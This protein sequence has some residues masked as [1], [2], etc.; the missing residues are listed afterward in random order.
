MDYIREEFM[1]QQ[2]ALLVLMNGH[3]QSVEEERDLPE[4]QES[5]AE[6][7]LDAEIAAQMRMVTA[8]KKLKANRVQLAEQETHG[9]VRQEVFAKEQMSIRNRIIRKDRM[10][11]A[12]GSAAEN[13]DMRGDEVSMIEMPYRMRSDFMVLI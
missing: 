5:P 13:G 11:R 12:E 8:E 4:K 3:I 10:I 2:H 6:A 1:R 9:T 7:G